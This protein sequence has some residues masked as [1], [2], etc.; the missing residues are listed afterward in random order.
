MARLEHQGVEIPTTAEAARAEVRALKTASVEAV[1]VIFDAMKYANRPGLP[2]MTPEILAAILDEAQLQGLKVYAR[3]STLRYAKE[4]LRAGGDGLLHG[5]VDEL[6]DDEFLSLMKTGGRFYIATMTLMESVHDVAGFV[7]REAEFDEQR[8]NPDRVYAAFRDPQVVEQANA[9]FGGPIPEENLK[10]MR[11]NLKRV[12]KQW[13][14]S[15]HWYRYGR[16][17]CDTGSGESTGTG[18]VRRGR[19]YACRSSPG[20]DIDS[21]TNP[22]TRQRLGRDRSWEDCRPGGVGWESTEGY[23]QHCE[24]PRGSEE[25]SVEAGQISSGTS[26][27]SQQK[28]TRGNRPTGPPGPIRDLVCRFEAKRRAAARLAAASVTLSAPSRSFGPTTQFLRRSGR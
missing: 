5:I 7:R 11:A 25:R 13:N 1:K 8:R 4:F 28:M 12:A 27:P 19:P 10:I 17:G 21:T 3:A 26:R 20:L 14:T 6:V 9:R 23:S 16:A 18:V 2:A 15:R 22:R 24:D